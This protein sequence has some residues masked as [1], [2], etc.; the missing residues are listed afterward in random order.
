MELY[1]KPCR[2]CVWSLPFLSNTNTDGQTC[3]ARLWPLTHAS[4]EHWCHFA[5]LCLDSVREIPGKPAESQTLFPGHLGA[6]QGT[7]DG[8]QGDNGYKQEMKASASQTRVFKSKTI[9]LKS[10]QNFPQVIGTVKSSQN[11]QCHPG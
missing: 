8:W 11:G 9:L 7:R 10:F 6:G 2:L 5:R 3:Q 4:S 1:S